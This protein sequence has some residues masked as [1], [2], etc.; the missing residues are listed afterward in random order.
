[1]AQSRV[2]ALER[3]FTSGWRKTWILTK[4]KRLVAWMLRVVK[5]LKKTWKRVCRIL[6][7][8][9]RGEATAAASCLRAERS[10]P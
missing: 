8:L 9:S 4:I 10:A 5:S 7:L 1:M 3:E 6:H 2:G